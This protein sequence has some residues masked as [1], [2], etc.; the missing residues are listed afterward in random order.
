MHDQD[1]STL[2]PSPPPIPPLTPD[3]AAAQIVIRWAT[4]KL[5]IVVLALRGV[6]A[7]LPIPEEAEEM[8]TDVIPES[9]AFSLAGTVECILNDDLVPAVK[10]LDDA[11][12]LT[13]TALVRDWERRTGQRSDL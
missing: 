3:E 4:A 7:G 10:S 5:R 8:G 1:K 11:A 9:L 12:V 2:P 6:V 13:P